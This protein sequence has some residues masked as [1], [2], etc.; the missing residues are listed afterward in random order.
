MGKLDE[1]IFNEVNSCAGTSQDPNKNVRVY[2]VNMIDTGGS[3]RRNEKCW[4][5]SECGGA[6][7]ARNC[8][9]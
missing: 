3:L 8:D 7:R 5:E 1:T 9:L 6:G 2:K 4:P